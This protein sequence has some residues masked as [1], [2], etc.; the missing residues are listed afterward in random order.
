[1][2][3]ESRYAVI[4]LQCLAVACA[5]KKCNIFQAGL[6]HFTIVTDHNP[7]ISILNSHHLDGIENPSC[8]ICI[9]VQWLIG[10]N[11]GVADAILSSPT[12]L[13][14]KTV[15]SMKQ[16]PGNTQ[17][18]THNDTVAFISTALTIATPPGGSK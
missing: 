9:S 7:L 18:G 8:Y 1:M 2:D 3:T 12:P 4:E 11:N 16:I 5:I 13:L 10:T 6:Q 14:V 17:S 15:R